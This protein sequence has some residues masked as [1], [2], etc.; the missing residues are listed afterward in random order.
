MHIAETL[1]ESRQ[2]AGRTRSDNWPIG[3]GICGGSTGQAHNS[4]PTVANPFG[5][6]SRNV[7]QNQRVYH[8]T[9]ILSE[10]HQ[11]LVELRTGEVAMRRIG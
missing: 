11:E 5:P 3:C 1:W 6:F 7:Q 8:V 2:Q 4:G 9:G 10:I